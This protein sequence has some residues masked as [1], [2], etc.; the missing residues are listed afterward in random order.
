MGFTPYT[1]TKIFS[2]SRGRWLERGPSSG[3]GGGTVTLSHEDGGGGGGGIAESAD[4]A[5]PE[6]ADAAALLAEAL[7]LCCFLLSAFFLT[8]SGV[9]PGFASAQAWCRKYFATSRF[10]FQVLRWIE[11]I[12]V[13]MAEGLEL[14][15]HAATAF[16]KLSKP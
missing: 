6:A 8:I 3:G 4:T 2:P 5:V 10:F 14:D 1:L 13:R 7:S 16:V 11:I 12:Y 9:T 15:Y